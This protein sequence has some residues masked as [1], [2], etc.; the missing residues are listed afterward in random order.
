M[1]KEALPTIST[2][3]PI[4]VWSLVRGVRH[5]VRLVGWLI[6][7]PLSVLFEIHFP[8]FRISGIISWSNHSLFF[9]V[10]FL[11]IFYF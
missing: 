9:S 3:S 8:L 10:W 7:S 6:F 4:T 2:I 11:L 5:F 1:L